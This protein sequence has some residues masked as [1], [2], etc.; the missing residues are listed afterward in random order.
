[1]SSPITNEDGIDQVMRCI[2]P[3]KA[4][5]GVKSTHSVLFSTS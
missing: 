5:L 2:A 3:L 4:K 1:M